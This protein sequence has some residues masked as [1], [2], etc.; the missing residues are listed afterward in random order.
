MLCW[1]SFEVG[2]VYGST[3]LGFVDYSH[4][5]QDRF[6]KNRRL[7]RKS[8]DMSRH[9]S[10]TDS[11]RKV[12][13]DIG[14]N[15]GT[16]FVDCQKFNIPGMCKDGSWD[17]IAVEANPAYT[18]T[19]HEKSNRLIEQK[20]VSSIRIYNS[21]VLDIEGKPFARFAI[22]RSPAGQASSKSRDALLFRNKVKRKK[23]HDILKLPTLTMRKLFENSYIADTDFV[24]L[25]IDVEGFEYD[26]LPHLIGE[27]FLNRI[28]VLA[29]EYHDNNIWF[30]EGLPEHRVNELHDQ[31]KCL[32]WII[33][34]SD[35]TTSLIDWD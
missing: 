12:Y 15:D 20:L 6:L 23:S 24:V 27:G 13:I 19:L 9:A 18:A 17:I 11:Q 35:R 8:N 31:T 16:S 3:S 29:V 25:K 32:K 30:Y 26:L 7:L 4:T 21:T 2:R 22:D 33:G 5:E 14:A 1:L 10:L 34:K 28:D